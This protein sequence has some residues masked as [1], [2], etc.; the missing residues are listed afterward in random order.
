MHWISG[1]CRGFSILNG[2]TFRNADVHFL[3][4]SSHNVSHNF[5]TWLI[6]TG[7]QTKYSLSQSSGEDPHRPGRLC[8]AGLRKI[9]DD[10]CSF[11]MGLPEARDAAQNQSFWRLLASQ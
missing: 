8:S 10:R 1:A 11:D 4:L 5:S 3:P 9:T 2:R 6:W 7:R